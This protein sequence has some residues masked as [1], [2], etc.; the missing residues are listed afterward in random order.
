MIASEVE[1]QMNA[2]FSKFPPVDVVKRLVKHIKTI[3]R[4]F[5]NVTAE[6]CDKDHLWIKQAA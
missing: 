6:M 2:D 1:D 5:E 3:D 4:R